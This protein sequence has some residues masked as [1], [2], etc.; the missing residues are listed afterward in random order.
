MHIE[1]DAEDLANEKAR[2]ELLQL[3]NSSFK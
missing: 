2:K 3:M 1:K